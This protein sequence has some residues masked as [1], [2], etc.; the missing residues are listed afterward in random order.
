MVKILTTFLVIT[1]ITLM[2]LCNAQD[3]ERHLILD[4]LP[5]NLEEITLKAGKIFSGIC[6]SIEEIDY[7]AQSKLP[8]TKYKFQIAE[9]I[10]G[11]SEKEITFKQW[12]ALAKRTSY[13]VGKKY[14]LF[15]YPES[16]LGL[17]STVG[18]LQGHFEIIKVKTLSGVSEV[19][20][21]KLNNKGLIRNLRTQKSLKIKDN[22][23]LK[24]YL[25]KASEKGEPIKYSDFVEVI[26]CFIK[27]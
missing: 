16:T 20:I 18:Y 14:L 25:R 22:L 19:V 10:K 23:Q 6:I 8:V 4:T 26:N 15:I 11:V 12:Q 5:L 24:E 1:V 3:V 9:N 21:N 2:H 27:K 17:T 7:D 13:E